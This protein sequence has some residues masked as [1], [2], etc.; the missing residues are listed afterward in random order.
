MRRDN[1]Q[2]WPAGLGTHLKSPENMRIDVVRLQ[3]ARVLSL[4]YML[5]SY[6]HDARSCSKLVGL[7]NTLWLPSGCSYSLSLGCCAGMVAHARCCRQQVS[8]NTWS[9]CTV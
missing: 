3:P 2:L 7:Q 1:G 4:R 6:A 9:A 5:A 8:D